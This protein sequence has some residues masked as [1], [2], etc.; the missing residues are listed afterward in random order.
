MVTHGFMQSMVDTAA[1]SWQAGVIRFR[2]GTS[3]P[4]VLSSAVG[5]LT[6]ALKASSLVPSSH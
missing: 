6:E 5:P 2:A 3:I 1:C 4:L